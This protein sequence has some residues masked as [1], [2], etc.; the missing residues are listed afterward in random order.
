M[1]D[2]PDAT[3][4][5]ALSEG[6]IVIQ[7]CGSCARHV[8]F[9]RVLCPHCGGGRLDWV[10]A[11]GDGVVYSTTVVRQR[12]ER[13][14]DHNIALVDLA[15]GVRMMSRVEGLAPEDVTIGLSVRAFVGEAAGR[16]VVLFRP[17]GS[18]T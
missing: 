18:G 14:G 10:E 1:A 16:P 2:G 11:S 4:Q 17:A 13:G 15:E 12:P 5:A 3:F 8:F 9:P 6:R 7:R